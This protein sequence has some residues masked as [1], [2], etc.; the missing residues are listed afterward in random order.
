[1][2]L[3]KYIKVYLVT[4]LLLINITMMGVSALLHELWIHCVPYSSI[5]QPT[6]K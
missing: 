6:Y 5:E 1:M 4:S 2:A 3:W